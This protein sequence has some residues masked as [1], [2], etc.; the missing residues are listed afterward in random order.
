[1]LTITASSTCITSIVR[2]YFLRHYGITSDP[3]W[4]NTDGVIWSTL[5]VSTGMICASMPALRAGFSGVKSSVSTYNPSSRR[6]YLSFSYA[7]SRSAQK[8]RSPDDSARYRSTDTLTRSSSIHGGG[9]KDLENGKIW[10][11]V[12]VDQVSVEMENCTPSVRRQ[13]AAAVSGL[14]QAMH[15]R[16]QMIKEVDISGLAR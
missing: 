4:D 1:M 5:E 16:E 8:K 11:L 14:P 15:S 13:C 7:S 10:K 12:S 6:S 9:S 3:T 2:L